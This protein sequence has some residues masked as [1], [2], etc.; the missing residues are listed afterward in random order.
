MSADDIPLTP[1]TEEQFITDHAPAPEISRCA[2]DYVL[3]H[4]AIQADPFYNSWRA[5][6][7]IRA[8]LMWQLYKGP[9][10]EDMRGAWR[11]VAGYPTIQQMGTHDLYVSTDPS[12]CPLFFVA[13]LWRGDGGC[14]CEGKTVEFPADVAVYT[15]VSVENRLGCAVALDYDAPATAEA[16]RRAFAWARDRCGADMIVVGDL[17]RHESAPLASF[18]LLQTGRWWWEDVVPVVAEPWRKAPPVEELRAIFRAVTW[19]G[20][21]ANWYTDR[22]FWPTEAALAAVAADPAEPFAAVLRRIRTVEPDWSLRNGNMIYSSAYLSVERELDP[23]PDPY[24]YI[25]VWRREA[26]TVRLSN[27]VIGQFEQCM[28][29]WGDI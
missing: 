5:V 24:D 17:A 8:I 19:G 3:S 20:F 9:E 26:S 4:S 23:V 28:G 15:I 22:R 29:D 12:G 2:G 16:A 13:R 7:T 6:S 14:R 10:W 27:P 21:L 18:W 11:P 1:G 25:C